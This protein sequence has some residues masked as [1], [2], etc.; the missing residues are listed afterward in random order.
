MD[1]SLVQYPT[2]ITLSHGLVHSCHRDK[3][4]QAYTSLPQRR[5]TSSN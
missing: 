3:S 1:V 4:A 5:E 2:L